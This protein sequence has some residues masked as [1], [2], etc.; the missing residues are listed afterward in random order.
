MPLLQIVLPIGISF[1]TFKTLTYTIDVYRRKITPTGNFVD[2]AL[3]L[4]FFPQLLAG[5]IDRASNL[6][7]QISSPRQI[8]REKIISGLNLVLVGYFKKVAIADTLSP[9]V[10]QI[11]DA[12]EAMSCGQ[13]WAGVYGYSF[14]IYGDFSG[15]TDIS[16]GISRI[17]GFETM[18]N[19]NSPYLSRSIMEF[20]R[21]WHISLSSWLRDYLYI[22]LG[23]NRHGN[24]RTYTNLMI[25]M[26]LCGLWHGAAWN[27]VLW[28][29]LHGLC[30]A[31]H[32][33]T[34]RGA[35]LDLAWP[36]TILG[37]F[38]QLV[39]IF[40]TFHFVTLAWVLFRSPGLDSALVYYQ[41]LFRL[42]HLSDFPPSILFAGAMLIALD[43]IQ[44][45]HGTETWLTGSKN[46]VP[47]R[48][49]IVQAMLVGILSASIASLG[50]LT[51]FI[52]FQF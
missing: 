49:A 25:T 26:S 45:R 6:L 24:V 13:L 35:K 14:Q 16:R 2:Y 17:L 3:F 20:W 7:P 29:L 32:R 36:A 44:T 15:Y 28:G 1:Y 23:G 46:Y 27:F 21:R 4:S 30:L 34:L 43:V 12:P 19:F 47:F 48:Y 42:E 39:K 10:S 31:G 38:I 5:P 9:I 8:T 33:I 37:W 11:F 50:T 40:V 22:P 41:G 51:P 52:Y 18:E